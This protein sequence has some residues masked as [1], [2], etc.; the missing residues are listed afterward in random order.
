MIKSI[1][2][3]VVIISFHAITARSPAPPNAKA[4]KKQYVGPL[5]RRQVAAHAFSCIR[6]HHRRRGTP[7]IIVVLRT[8]R[9][10][11]IITPT[12]S[13][14]L[15]F[16]LINPSTIHPCIHV[17][18]CPLQLHLL[19]ARICVF[20]CLLVLVCFAP[21]VLYKPPLQSFRMLYACMRVCVCPPLPSNLNLPSPSFPFVSFVFIRLFLPS[22][23][24][25]RCVCVAWTPQ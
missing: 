15:L 22:S 18:S 24:Q 10:L 5:T 17:P 9:P 3:H 19:L 16:L 23:V 8:V 2:T 7:S 20:V 4:P 13:A 12:H 1:T 14:D 21:S 11:F 6:L 25:P